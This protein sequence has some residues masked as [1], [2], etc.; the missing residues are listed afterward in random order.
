[1]ADEFRITHFTQL[2]A[3]KTSHELALE[4]YKL[5]ETFPRNTFSLIDQ[6]RRSS[7]S[8]SSNIAEGFSRKNKKEKIQFY[9]IAKGSLTELQNQL[10]LSKDLSYISEETFNILSEKTNLAYKLLNGLIYS[11]ETKL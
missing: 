6:I 7:L 3:W 1:M 5:T 11:A 8:I 4:V 2:I 10:I 9:Y